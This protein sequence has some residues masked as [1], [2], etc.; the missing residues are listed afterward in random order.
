V[1]AGGRVPGKIALL[2]ALSAQGFSLTMTLPVQAAE[3]SGQMP[4]KAP[5]DW[6]GFYVGAH[7]GEAWGRSH[8]TAWDA[9]AGTSAIG[10]LNV[11][12]FYDAFGGTGSYFSGLHAGY[13]KLFNSRFLIGVEADVTFPNTVGGS[14]TFSSASNGQAR[15]EEF[16]QFSGTVRSRIGY[17]QGGWLLYAT[18]GLAWSFDQFSRTQL[19]GVPVSGTAVPGT[20]ETR[21]MVPRI[22]WAAGAGIEVALTSHWNARIEYL[23]TGFGNRSVSFPAGAQTFNSDL[24][25]QSIRLGLNYRIGQSSDFFVKGPDALEMDRFAF[26]AQTTYVHQYAFPFRSPYRGQNSLVPNQGRETWDVTGYVGAR[27]WQG[28][29]FWI[30]PEI[31]QGFGLS[32]TLGAAGFTSGEAY[33]VGASVPYTRLPRMFVRQTI[34]L[35]GDTQKV[36]AGINQ[37]AGSQTANRI[38]LTVGKFSV[39]DIFDTN[40]Y[41]HDP[42]ADFMN[43][44]LID[45]G[46]FDYASDAWGFTYGAAAEWYQGAWTLRFGLF[47][48]SV[49]PNSTILDSSFKQFQSI[50]ELEHRHEIAGQPG[51]IAVTGFLTRGRMGRFDDAVRLSELTGEPANT[52]LVRRY[53]SRSGVSFNLEQQV[54]A[55]LGVFARAGIAGGA[56][57]PYEFTDI[58]RT[59]AAGLSLAGKQW[60]RPDDTLGIAGVV[61]GISDAHKAYFNAAG[62]GILVG[63]GRLPNP[64]PEKIAEIY[65]S[66]PIANWRATLDYQFIANPG[67]NRDRGP[68]SVIGTRLRAQF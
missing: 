43:W 52:A 51:K 46:T 4:T 36:E 25:L 33:K 65:Y 10:T 67:Y 9:G 23:A 58:D 12:S 41:V 13:N 34:D 66:F 53:Q 16:V 32:G 40:K 35:G 44:S 5:A 6:S 20:V 59:V 21:F 62:L 50:V 11:H 26:H 56:I 31:D 60:G 57:E 64:G 38:V 8:V 2:V 28:A 63:D 39:A 15:Y 24:A 1:Q 3:P 42:R 61:N 27:L 30:N 49:V 55:D 19:A 17:A 54:T 47:D 37:F 29:E 68:A 7:L 18:A 48:L 45:T 14:L 22:G